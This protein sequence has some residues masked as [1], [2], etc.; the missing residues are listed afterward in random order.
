MSAPKPYLNPEL[1]L[2]KFIDFVLIFVGLYAA[3]ALQRHQDTERERDEYVSLLRDFQRELSANLAQE[4]SIEKDLGPLDVSAPGENLGPMKKTFLH[5][6]EELETDERIVHC[7]HDEFAKSVDAKLPSTGSAECH[8]TYR[9]FDEA[10]RSG[11]Q[12]FAFAP[13]VLTP[14]YRYEVWELY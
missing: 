6:F 8:T 14:F 4:A 5:F 11:E 13:A 3:T 9:L 7:L 12:K 2:D 10:H 1:L